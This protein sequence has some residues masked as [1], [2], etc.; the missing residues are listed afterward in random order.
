MLLNCDAGEDSRV[1][2]VA[3]RSNPSI[4]KEISPEYSSEGLM[5]KLKLKY[6][7]PLMGRATY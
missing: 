4:V 5:M 1:P 6:V 2:W 3:K 7:G